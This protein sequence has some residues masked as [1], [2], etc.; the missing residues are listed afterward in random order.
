MI[1][2]KRLRLKKSVANWF[3]VFI[4]SV[5]EWVFLLCIY[6]IE[7]FGRW[8]QFLQYLRYWLLSLIWPDSRPIRSKFDCGLKCVQRETCQYTVSLYGISQG[9]S[10]ARPQLYTL[11]GVWTVNLQQLLPVFGRYPI[12]SSSRRVDVVVWIL[13]NIALQGLRT[14]LC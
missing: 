12:P 9:M 1:L 11:Y 14:R 7:R 4:D 10:T 2:S 3:S 13:I 6:L 5:V 8:K